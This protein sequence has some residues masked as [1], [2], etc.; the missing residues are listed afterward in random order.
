MYNIQL[1]S[2]YLFNYDDQTNVIIMDFFFLFSWPPSLFLVFTDV[3]TVLKTGPIFSAEIKRKTV[4]YYT[5]NRKKSNF[6]L[7]NHPFLFNLKIFILFKKDTIVYLSP[8][9]HYRFPRKKCRNHKY[10]VCPEHYL[11][12]SPYLPSQKIG[13]WNPFY[14]KTKENKIQKIKSQVTLQKLGYITYG[15]KVFRQFKFE[16]EKWK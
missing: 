14:C 9:D 5:I 4:Y 8:S 13:H 1:N 6:S 12:I 10:S 7:F 16:V 3:V 2:I 11:V 15:K